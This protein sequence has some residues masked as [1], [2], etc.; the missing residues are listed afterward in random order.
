MQDVFKIQFLHQGPLPFAHHITEADLQ[1]AR[2]L[3]ADLTHIN[4]EIEYPPEWETLPRSLPT[5]LA[6]FRKNAMANQDAKAAYL[7]SK[8]NQAQCDLLAAEEKN[9]ALQNLSDTILERAKA[10]EAKVRKFERARK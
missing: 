6:T 2:C 10:A 5:V 7:E 4:D 1:A 3:S 8:L 9:A